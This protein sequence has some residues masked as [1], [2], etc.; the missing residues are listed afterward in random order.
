MKARLICK[1]VEF[2]CQQNMYK[3]TYK[4]ASRPAAIDGIVALLDGYDA[5]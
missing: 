2:M 4:P 3:R 1:Y 5:S